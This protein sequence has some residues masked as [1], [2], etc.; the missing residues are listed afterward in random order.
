LCTGTDIFIVHGHDNEA[1]ETLARYIEH[2]GCTPIILHEKPSQGHT[3]IEKLE[4]YAN[5]SSFAVVLLTPDDIGYPKDRQDD[6]KPRARQNVILEL[7][8]FLAKPAATA[9]AQC[10]YPV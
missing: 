9:C 7:G 4:A 5:R 10:M 6:R 2:I 8:Y 1:K 3:V